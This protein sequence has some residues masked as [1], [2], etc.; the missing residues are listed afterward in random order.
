MKRVH[1][2]YLIGGILFLLLILCF[3][4]YFRP[5]TIFADLSPRISSISF[6]NDTVDL[7]TDPVCY[8]TY[9]KETSD[10][11]EI[12]KLTAELRSLTYSRSHLT[13]IYPGAE[14]I[15]I[16]VCYSDLAGP[17]VI[18]I[19]GPE[20]DVWTMVSFGS[21]QWYYLEQLIKDVLFWDLFDAP[22]VEIF[23]A[24]VS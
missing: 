12:Q 3:C 24:P 18:T 16:E 17:E 1:W 9:K 20:S 13:K 19:A 4:L 21:G 11:D 10:P 23:R 2:I 14:T 22:T 5:R 6:Y 8:V 7:D 15:K